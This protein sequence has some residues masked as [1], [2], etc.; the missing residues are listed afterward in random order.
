MRADIDAKLAALPSSSYVRTALPK[1]RLDAAF[2]APADTGSSA[3]ALVSFPPLILFCARGLAA[4]LAAFEE[5]LQRVVNQSRRK[6]PADVTRF[7]SAGVGQD[8]E[9][10]GGL[11][12]VHVRPASSRY[13]A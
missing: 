8:R 11:F 13:P 10:R 6:A 2:A 7:R 9:W 12:E 1:E 3:S 5:D 4:Q